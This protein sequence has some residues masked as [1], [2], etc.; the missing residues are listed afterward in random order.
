LVR[1]VAEDAPRPALF[2]AALD[3]LTAVPPTLF[4]VEDAHWAD[5]ATLDLL[6]F[7]GRR[8]QATR[9]LLLVTYRD[10]EVGPGHPLRVVTGD[11][12]TAV[13]VHRIG[14]APLSP[15]AVATLAATS[16]LDPV[17]LHRRTGGNPFFVT[18]V[19]AAGGHGLSATV[20]DA[21]LARVARLS[22]PARS[23]LEAAAVIGARVDPPLLDAIGGLDADAVDEC[24][25]GGML[26]TE[27][28]VLTFRHE[29]ARDAVL[30]AIPQWR[31]RRLHAAVLAG[32]QAD[33]VGVDDLARLAHHAEAAGDRE[34]VLRYA[35]AAGRR[36]EEL[37]A[38]REATAQYA[39]ALRVAGGLPDRERMALLEAYARISDLANWGEAAIGPRREMI[40]LARRLGDRG[41]E[42]E[43][44]GWLS[45]SLALEGQH[46][47][48]A[49]AAAEAQAALAG[50]P[51]GVAHAAMFCNQ[52]ELAWVNGD[53]AAAVAWGERAITLAERLGDVERTL[54]GRNT[55]GQAWLQAGDE[56]R[57]RGELERA[58]SL[59]R[60]AGLDGF[61]AVALSN[62]GDNHC[63]L[64]RLAEAD[65]YLSEGLAFAIDQDMDSLRWSM[66]PWLALVRLF[67]GRW[68]E[69]T[70]LAASVLRLPAAMPPDPHDP[71]T[72]DVSPATF[73]IPIYNRIVALLALGRVRT[74]R[75][76]PGAWD[77]LDEALALAAPRGTFLRI[78]RVRTA[79]AEAAWLAGDRERT[80]AEARAAFDGPIGHRSPWLVGEL[81]YW[82]W[83]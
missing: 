32:L 3:A 15:T 18:E 76:D 11:L 51:E 42:A 74:R 64:Y 83:R 21:V 60:E 10:D 77:A 69:A 9:S 6:R 40:G 24:L 16:G 25:D 5:E 68:T 26:R 27:Q 12:A 7:L 23:I 47:E 73:G 30:A 80:A 54:L 67:Q 1:L 43:H 72:W 63:R 34:A 56:A 70:D 59:A 65:R 28:D 29:L 49:R 8:I 22:P 2:R 75:G 78:A 31:R 46:D 62:L 44:L 13:A 36:A 82:L 41:K 53:L 57:G 58:L 38:G 35:P 81:A 45:I 48:A 55:V 39:R 52:A 17:A 20:H 4:V 19:L 79:R 50:V 14:L 71:V 66:V 61:V 33:P 37:R